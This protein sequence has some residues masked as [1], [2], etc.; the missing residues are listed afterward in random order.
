M[1]AASHRSTLPGPILLKGG[2]VVDPMYRR[3]GMFDVRIEDGQIVQVVR[4]GAERAHGHI[5]A[6]G[7]R[8]VSA[9]HCAHAA[10]ILHGHR[11]MMGHLHVGGAA[12]VL[13][14]RGNA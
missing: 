8:R 10:I 12:F 14:C 11:A 6:V 2:R 4:E 5:R 3:D 9:M 13:R 1:T 7:R